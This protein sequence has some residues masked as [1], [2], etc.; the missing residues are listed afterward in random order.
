VHK[1]NNLLQLDVRDQLDWDPQLDDDRIV[2]AANDGIVTLSGSVPTY[3]DVT[4]ASDDVFDVGGVR[5]V[6]NQLL[7]GPIGEA[8]DDRKIEAA[9]VDALDA[10]RLVPKEAVRPAV[11]DGWVT[12]HGEVRHHYQRLA[13]E[14]AVG[15]VTG[16]LGMDD[17]VTITSGPLP[18]DVADRVQKALHRNAAVDDSQ[19]TVTNDGSSV[20]LHGTAESWTS[21]QIAEDTAWNAPGVT[22]VVDR[23]A[24]RA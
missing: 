24:V 14:R 17:D 21:R 12:L 1:L 10:E 22:D 19:I 18:T 5:G 4:R 9:C 16:V 13:A 6:D 11:S 3:F 8:M 2:V 7:V 15:R 20:Y 23:V